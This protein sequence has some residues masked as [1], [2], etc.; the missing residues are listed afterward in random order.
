[1]IILL[2]SEGLGPYFL[3]ALCA[4]INVSFMRA[5]LLGGGGGG[6]HCMVC[7]NIP[8]TDSEGRL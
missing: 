2:D 5:M 3:R 7:Y 6:L 1:M 4:G 8:R